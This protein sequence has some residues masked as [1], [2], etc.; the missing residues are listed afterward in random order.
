M[1]VQS[2][3]YNETKF[4]HSNAIASSIRFESIGIYTWVMTCRRI[5]GV[6]VLPI[7]HFH[8]VT[9]VALKM[10]HQFFFSAFVLRDLICGHC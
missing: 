9:V 2:H 3:A 6:H 5:I 10:I 7:L 8:L 4:S 1:K